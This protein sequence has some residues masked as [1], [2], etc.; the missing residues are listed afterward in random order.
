MSD[1][2][3]TERR[4]DPDLNIWDEE[5]YDPQF[6]VWD[7]ESG[8]GPKDKREFAAGSLNQLI[9]RLTNPRIES[10]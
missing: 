9:L 3:K 2:G 4:Y 6:V 8:N 5:E 1:E 7:E 10:R